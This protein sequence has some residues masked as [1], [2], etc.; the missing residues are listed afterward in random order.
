MGALAL[1]RVSEAEALG[2]SSAV[3]VADAVNHAPAGADLSPGDFP[4]PVDLH[5]I[6][7]RFPDQWA[8][9]LRSHFQGATHIAAFFDVDHRTARDW[10]SGKHGATAP[11]ALYAIQ[12]IPGALQELIGGIE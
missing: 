11:V 3:S 9:F 7:R 6:R 5:G 8:H 4:H 1:C 10:L 12:C 2:G